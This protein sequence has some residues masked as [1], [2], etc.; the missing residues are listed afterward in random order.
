MNTDGT[1]NNS[2]RLLGDGNP[3]LYVERETATTFQIRTGLHV[4]CVVYNGANSATYIDDSLEPIVGPIDLGTASLNSLFTGTYYNAPAKWSWT[5]HGIY[6]GA[7]DAD[8]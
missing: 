3:Y 8:Q 7:H 6:A 4:I 5:A 2:L 1:T